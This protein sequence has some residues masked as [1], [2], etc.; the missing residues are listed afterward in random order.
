MLMSI[1][2]MSICVLDINIGHV[3]IPSQTFRRASARRRAAMPAS[4][5]ACRLL[6]EPRL[7]ALRTRLLVSHPSS[8]WE[9]ARATLWQPSRRSPHH[10]RRGGASTQQRCT[11]PRSRHS[12]PSARASRRT[13][14]SKTTTASMSH[15]QRQP[16]RRP[17]CRRAVPATAPSCSHEVVVHHAKGARRNAQ[18]A[19]K[20]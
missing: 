11:W 2:F 3:S 15:G 17:R 14:A 12:Q 6:P 20:L 4:A 8:P 7:V 10:G 5:L 1:L 9:K 16:V 19:V 18:A 13:T